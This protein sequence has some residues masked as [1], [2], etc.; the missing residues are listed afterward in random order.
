MS[1][2]VVT[3]H[4]NDLPGLQ[5]TFHS[6]QALLSAERLSWLVI[7][8]GSD[9]SA[10]GS[11]PMAQIRRA[12]SHFI[13]EPDNGIYD[14][15]NKGAKLAADDYL[16]FLNAGDQLHPSF[17]IDSFARRAAAS[18]GDML[19]GRS[20]ERYG[21]GR[22]VPVRTRSRAWAWYGMP[23]CHQAI[24]FKRTALGAEPYDTHYAIGADYDLVCRL[25]AN[26]ATVVPLDSPVCIFH[27]GGVSSRCIKASLEEENEIRL[28]YHKMPAAFGSA[29]KY[30][31]Q[32]NARLAHWAWLRRLW[33]GR[34]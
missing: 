30:F 3:V 8:G 27:R 12:A 31:K 34:L 33:R 5:R 10:C 22:L 11:G 9:A 1:L 4:L 26:G 19:W 28:K 14:A 13:S 20:L 32:L 7:D 6:L 21:D 15:M 23:V 16:L 18:R 25:L 17:D 2:A 24:F 29:L